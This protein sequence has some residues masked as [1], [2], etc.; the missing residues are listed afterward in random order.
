MSHDYWKAIQAEDMAKA[1]EIIE[2][3]DLPLF[4][5][6]QPR[7]GSFDAWFHGMYEL[8][9]LCGRWRRPPYY[10]LSDAEMEQLRDFLKKQRLL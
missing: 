8:Y 7:Q 5:F 1:V 3:F 6:I 4:E 10:S 2:T 9:G